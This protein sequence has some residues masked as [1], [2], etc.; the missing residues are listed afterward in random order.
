MPGFRWVGAGSMDRAIRVGFGLLNLCQILLGC[1]SRAISGGF[2]FL[3][4]IDLFALSWSQ[5]GSRGFTVLLRS[6]GNPDFAGTCAP[7]NFIF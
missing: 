5:L 2:S 4:I 1:E 7:H 3:I 6:K